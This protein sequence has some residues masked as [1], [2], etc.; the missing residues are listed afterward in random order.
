MEQI[1]YILKFILQSFLHV[2]PYLLV[3][4]PLAVWMNLSDFSKY[5]KAIMTK[6]P[7]LSIFLATLIGAISPFCSCGVIPVITALLIGGVPLAPVFAFW[8]ASPSMDPEIFFL[9]VSVLGWKL[10]IWRLA[11]TFALSI[12]AGVITH[13]LVKRGYITTFLRVKTE[14]PVRPNFQ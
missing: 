2:W 5:F 14:K 3:T 7:W 9:S 12:M 13:L 4:I 10:A 1:T 11:S 6:S 8:V